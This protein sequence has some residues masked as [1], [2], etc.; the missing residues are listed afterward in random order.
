MCGTK[1]QDC[2]NNDINNHFKEWENNQNNCPPL[3]AI[4]NKLDN[5]WPTDIE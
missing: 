1:D 5:R 4:I 2:E 3:M